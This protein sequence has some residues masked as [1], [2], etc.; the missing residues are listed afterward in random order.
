[1][2]GTIQGLASHDRPGPGNQNIRSGR[3]EYGDYRPDPTMIK[4]ADVAE[5]GGISRC[6]RAYEENNGI[7]S[8]CPER[9]LRD[10]A[11]E[12]GP[13]KAPTTAVFG[14]DRAES[15]TQAK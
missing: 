3:H 7:R 4:L 13:M 2:T 10:W 9:Q 8:R 5:R 1:M 6:S 15:P 11:R 12:A 14:T